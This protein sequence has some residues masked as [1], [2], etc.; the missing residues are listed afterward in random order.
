MRSGDAGPEQRDRSLVE[1]VVTWTRLRLAGETPE[2]A[3]RCCRSTT[4]T[5]ARSSGTGSDGPYRGTTER[6]PGNSHESS[7]HPARATHFF[8]SK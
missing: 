8:G 7:T 6:E 4:P 3:I 2:D 1:R 5:P